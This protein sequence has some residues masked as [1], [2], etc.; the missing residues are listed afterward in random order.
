MSAN[1]V[2]M[3]VI[4]LI[5]LQALCGC[6]NGPT[7]QLGLVPQ[8]RLDLATAPRPIVRTAKPAAAPSISSSPDLWQTRGYRLWKYIVVHHS[9]TARGNAA[10]FDQSHRRRGWDELGYHFVIDNG[11]GGPDGRIEVGSRWTKQKWGAHT[12]GTP[13]NEYNNHG[14]GI[15]LVG[16]F[17]TKM[18]SRAQIASLERLVQHLA[19]KYRIDPDNVIGHRE[20]PNATT[21]CP[22][23]VFMNWVTRGLRPRLRTQLAAMR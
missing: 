3:S 8:H 20:G 23:A 10:S 11:D 21:V 16:D 2:W 18:P 7:N 1:K 22:G 9:A 4:A 19:S 6:A 12:G 13:N 5:A 14:I 17:S 15:C